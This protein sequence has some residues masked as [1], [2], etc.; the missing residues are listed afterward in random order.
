MTP[1]KAYRDIDSTQ[2][3]EKAQRIEITLEEALTRTLTRTLEQVI[4]TDTIG[5]IILLRT[6]GLFEIRGMFKPSPQPFSQLN[7]FLITGRSIATYDQF[8]TP[9]D[10]ERVSERL[11]TN[12]ER[13]YVELGPGFSELCAK[14]AEER[15]WT[16][17]TKPVI[18]DTLD[19]ERLIH[20]L[21]TLEQYRPGVLQ[22]ANAWE[23]TP[24]SPLIAIQRLAIL[25]NPELV[26]R[27]HQPF[28]HA[29]NLPVTVT[30]IFRKGGGIHTLIDF[31]A[32]ALRLH[33]ELRGMQAYLATD[34]KCYSH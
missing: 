16:N 9:P 7:G 10:S 24:L 22:L 12:R 17:G 27:I 34:G 15:S 3:G 33:K 28:V 25:S 32:V 30:D 8:L 23:G 18:I 20:I 1:L 14:E 6:A 21:V 13:T 26:T 5:D 19:H 2:H 4:I 29:H 31:Q 11:R